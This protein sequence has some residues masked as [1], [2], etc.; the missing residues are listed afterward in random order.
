MDRADVRMIERGSRFGFA[1]ETA[2][3]LLVFGDFIR[4]EFQ[5][6]ESAKIYVLGLVHHSHAA[7]PE[8]LDDAV[9]RDCLADKLGRRSHWPERF[10]KR[11]T[12]AAPRRERSQEL[13]IK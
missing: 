9:V 10:R 5:R 6:Y 13:K 2:K 11:W 4:Q 8:L 3:R 7:A 12:N 1:L